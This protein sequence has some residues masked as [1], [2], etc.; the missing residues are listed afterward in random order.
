MAEVSAASRQRRLLVLSST[1]PRWQGDPE[2][3]FVHELAQRLVGRFEVRVI[4]PHADGA[5]RE[6]TLDG[7]HVCRYR[8]AP[9]SMETLVNNGGI[10]TNLRRSSWKWLLVPSF[11][12]AQWWVLRR[13]MRDFRPDVAHAHWLLPQG[14]IAAQA[15]GMVPVLVT[16]HG[17]DLF[18]LRGALFGWLRKRVIRRVAVLSVVSRAMRQ[19][20]LVEAPGA[21]VAV[22]P[23]GVDVGRQFC[24][25]ASERSQ[26][27]LLF[28]GRL[29]E[30]K[31]LLHLI[32]AM[33]AILKS[34]PDTSLT[35]IGFGPEQ[36][37]LESCAIELGLQEKIR[38]LGALPQQALP[39]YYRRASLFVAP[40][41]EADNGDQEGLGL[42]VAEAMACGCPVLV[43]DVPGVRDLID[44]K[45]GMRVDAS[46][47]VA[48]AAAIAD[49]LRNNDYRRQLAAEGRAH[50]LQHYAWPSVV[51]KYAQLL[52]TL[53]SGAAT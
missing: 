47:H 32:Q 51:E 44:G 42:V 27:E 19:R 10:L 5:A 34:C 23:M 45:T 38:F 21:R 1:Y 46:D 3:A 18:G 14:L 35:V 8:Y 13:V 16:S 31:G 50:V 9:A 6:E 25:D 17:A 4:A 12:F 43:G 30:K 7:V 28:V 22:L 36:E 33:P 41:V 40:F 53:A 15:I 24:P 52:E 11:L 49:L 39:A 2:P 37:K 20:V 48:L 26:V 29:V